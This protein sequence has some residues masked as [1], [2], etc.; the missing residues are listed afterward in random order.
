M[1]QPDNFGYGAEEDLFR[2][3]A[4]KFFRKHGD[5]LTLMKLVAA[6]HDPYRPNEC[7]WDREAWKKMADLGWTTLAVPEEAGGL[8]MK[9]IAVATLLEEAGRAAFP[10][11]LI[12]TINATYVLAAC[13]TQEAKAYLQKIVEGETASLAVTNQQGSWESTDTDV[14]A[15]YSGST[16]SLAGTA[17]FV[18]DV[19]KATLLLVSAKSAAGVGLYAVPAN[20]P[21]INIIPD[22]II[23][24][25]RD[26]GHV[27]F[28]GV[29]IGPA[30]IVAVPGKG[31]IALDKAKPAI[32]TM[33]A[34]DMCGAAEWQLQ[35]TAAYAKQRVQFDRPIGSFQAIKHPIVNMMIKIDSARSL[36]FQA[37]CAIDHEPEEAEAF[38]CMAKASAS[39]MSAFCSERCVQCHGG[40][41][42]TWECFVHLYVKRQAHN[43]VLYGD[44]AYHRAKLADK[45][46]GPISA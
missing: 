1:A 31:N 6:D 20:Q 45:L 43:R 42:F 14:V 24:L 10:S 28:D 32:L 35:T 17:W 40:I 5:E 13:G 16:I 11:P 41:G 30:N 37:A 8:G 21:G 36:V 39:D 27:Q 38:A 18:Q 29:E 3:E 33:I 44:A 25:T 19:R 9:A 26:Q 2:T 4:R 22:A 7:Q 15:T 23:D 46:M 12:A 34:A